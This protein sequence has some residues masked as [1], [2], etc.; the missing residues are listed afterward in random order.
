LK[1]GLAGYKIYRQLAPYAPL[2]V[3]TVAGGILTFQDQTLRPSNT[4]TY[5]IAAFDGAQNH[6]GASNAATF[7]TLATGGDTTAPTVPSNL[8]LTYT[9]ATAV[10][11]DWDA[12]ADSGGSGLA[13]YQ[14]FR[15]G[16][17]ISGPSP[18][19]ALTYTDWSLAANTGYS[20]VVKAIDSAGNVSLASVSKSVFRDDFNRPNATGLS[21]T[22]WST[23][24]TW[25]VMSNQAAVGATVGWSA[26][27]LTGKTF[28]TFKATLYNASRPAD[29]NSGI[30]F[31]ANGDDKWRFWIYNT[32]AGLTYYTA[33]AGTTVTT[34]SI[35]YWT[36]GAFRVEADSATRT[37]KVYLNDTLTLNYTETDTTRR[38]TGQIGPNAAVPTYITTN[39]QVDDFVVEER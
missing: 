20:F 5:T 4:Y 11:L 10:R 29:A 26:E 15:E 8:R 19:T 3:G 7:T 18:V 27:P 25:N 12:S 1:A 2:P 21:N 39:V 24:G 14:V 13:G 16:T 28:G 35:P 32:V 9:G 34:A 31:W 6:S 38:N 37:I 36:S 30:T 23:Y 17:Q 33:S 22:N